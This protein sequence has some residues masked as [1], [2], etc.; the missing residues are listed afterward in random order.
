MITTTCFPVAWRAALATPMLA[1]CG[2]GPPADVD[3]S[4]LLT[5]TD[6]H[7][8]DHPT[9]TAVKWIGETLQRETNGR[10]RWRSTTRA[11]WAA[12]RKRSTWRALAP[13]TSPAYAGA[14]NNAFR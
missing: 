7:V 13:S 1:A 14:L 2:R 6:V 4:T 11:S 3:G 12:S 8:A 5:A 9:V 10:L